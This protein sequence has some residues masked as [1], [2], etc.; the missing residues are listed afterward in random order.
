MLFFLAALDVVL[1]FALAFAPGSAKPMVTGTVQHQHMCQLRHNG[2]RREMKS[3]PSHLHRPRKCMLAT[4]M[5]ASEGTASG[6]SEKPRSFRSFQ[7]LEVAAGNGELTMKQACAAAREL[8]SKPAELTTLDMMAALGACFASADV[9]S[10]DMTLEDVWGLVR[11][12]ES[13]QVVPNAMTCTHLLG[14]CVS[15]ATAGIADH[16]DGLAVLSWAQ[17]SGIHP[18]YVMVAQVMNLC[19]KA[20]PH[21]RTSLDALMEVLEY[22]KKLDPPVERNVFTYTSM[23]DAMAKYVHR[24]ACARA[25]VLVDDLTQPFHRSPKHAAMSTSLSCSRS[26]PLVPLPPSY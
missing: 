25:F 18:D 23:I 20:A 26:L 10:E 11:D 4:H 2:V 6:D 13:M 24:R 17:K 1:G 7:L 12:F 5:K 19:A 16:K 14:I 9:S 22:S 3:T 21:G 8:A 15:F